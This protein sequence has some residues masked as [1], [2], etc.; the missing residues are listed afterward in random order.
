M[1]TLENDIVWSTHK[2][3]KKIKMDYVPGPTTPLLEEAAEGLQ[4]QFRKLGHTT[5]SKPDNETNV[6]ITTASYAEPVKWRD[7]L[8][9][10]AR[11]RFGLD[12]LPTVVTI[13]QVSPNKFNETLEYL[14]KVLEKE[15]I[16]PDDY[17]FPGLAPSAYLTL[18]EQGKRGGP[19]LSLMRILQSQAKSIRIILIVGEESPLEAYT[20]DLVGAHPRTDASDPN[21]FYEELVYRILT[22]VSTSEIT[23][24]QVVGQPLSEGDWRKLNTPEAMRTAGQ[25]FG[26]RKFFTQMIRISDLVH[27]PAI[28]EAVSSQYSEG[29]FTT[30]DA[31]ISG[32]VATITGSARPV[33][34]DNLTDNEMAVIVGVRPDGMGALVRSVEGKRND[35]PSSEAVEMIEMDI[36]LPKIN[37]QLDQDGIVSNKKEGGGQTYEVPVARS[38]LHGHRGVRAYNPKLVEHVSL[39]NAFYHFPVSCSTEAQ[40]RAIRD[41]YA[42]SEALNDPKDPRQVIFTVL[43]GHGVVIAEKWVPEKVP[44]QVIWEFMDSGDLQVENFIPQGPLTFVSNEDEMMVL[45]YEM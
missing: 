6:I 32:L 41:A 15:V 45:K 37:I 1:S 11:K 5:S 4:E 14:E 44:F 25:E 35:P 42:R 22:A 23:N 3:L 7:A 33:D 43:P 30:W 21:A 40:A 34:K 24:H 18:Y 9:F 29:C 26:K 38:K 20:F 12:H 10:T 8:M 19:I 27:V 16:N 36:P 2:W 31:Q 28:D 17:D 13:M 39:D